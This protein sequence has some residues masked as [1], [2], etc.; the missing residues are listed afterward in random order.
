MSALSPQTEADPG[1][2]EFSSPAEA[3]AWLAAVPPAIGSLSPAELAAML[4]RAER[5]YD[6]FPEL[7]ARF[8]RRAL[9]R[10]V[11]AAAGALPDREAVPLLLLC[12][13]AEPSDPAALTELF[14]RAARAD[15]GASL[16]ALLR[17]FRPY[18]ALGRAEIGPVA[19]ALDPAPAAECGRLAAG[20][21]AGADG[22]AR[23]R[24]MLALAE[25]LKA[26]LKP[27]PPRSAA[28]P[29]RRRG[30]IGFASFLAQW[31][32]LLI[33]VPAA[34]LHA[35]HAALG[36]DGM[37]RAERHEA[38]VFCSGPVLN[39]PAGHYRVRVIGEAA[40]GAAYAVEALCRL[41]E[42]A[43][44][45]VCAARHVRDGPIAGTLAELVFCSDI[46]LRGF[47]VAVRVAP[48]PAALAVASLAITADRLRP[49][50]ED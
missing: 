6:R 50:P 24:H 28:F 33:E 20:E 11:R 10:Q 49:D 19:A 3:Q 4:L 26:R 8:P 27:P 1:D 38:G 9:L 21:P 37:L 48:P 29:A 35:D 39:L 12:A 7:L 13:A 17:L 25:R 2:A 18:A 40:A 41:G 44:P 34:Q 5:A 14:E 45:P 31:P 15:G 22:A 16:P 43:A 46:A 36:A 47:Q 23:R 32:D 30:E 42:R